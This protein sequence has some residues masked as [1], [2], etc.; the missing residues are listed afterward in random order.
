MV[1]DFYNYV[2]YHKNCIDGFSGF[3]IL[4][5]TNTIHDKAIIYPDVPSA[6]EVPPNID[7]KNIIIIDVAYNVEILKEIIKRAQKV[8]FIDHHVSIRND[9]INLHIDK[10]HE[11]IYDEYKSGVSLT[12]NYFFGSNNKFK[13]TKYSK[14]PRFVRYIEDN[15]IGAWK[16]KYTL[17]FI[18]GLE[19]NY[20]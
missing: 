10:P 11:I 1:N 14:V 19:V 5:Q 17:P 7:G 15:D 8:T 2:I 4:T 20:T 6:K 18:A 13:K 12:W 3:F 16:L 9:I